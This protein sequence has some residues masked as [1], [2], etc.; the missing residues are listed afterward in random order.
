MNRSNGEIRGKNQ[1]KWKK[2]TEK[3]KTVSCIKIL[4]TYIF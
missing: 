3:V 2:D 1:A 4:Y